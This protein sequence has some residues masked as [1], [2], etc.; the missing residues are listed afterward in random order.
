MSQKHTETSSQ[1]IKLA[2]KTKEYKFQIRA[3]VVATVLTVVCLLAGVLTHYDRYYV[4]V[5]WEIGFGAAFV[6]HCVIQLILYACFKRRIK[7]KKAADIRAI[8]LDG[9][10]AATDNERKFATAIK[11]KYVAC[12]LYI[13]L[14]F[15][16][17]LLCAFVG[18]FTSTGIWLSILLAWPG[19]IAVIPFLF[20]EDC[21][22]KGATDGTLPQSDFPEIYAVVNRAMKAVGIKKPVYVFASDEG[23]ACIYTHKNCFVVELGAPLLALLN[24]EELYSVLLHELGHL[25]DIYYGT[26]KPQWLNMAIDKN[27]SNPLC[28][29]FSMFFLGHIIASYTYNYVVYSISVSERIEYRA[30]QVMVK[31]CDAQVASDAMAKISYIPLYDYEQKLFGRNNYAD[32]EAPQHATTVLEQ[33]FLSA[34]ATEKDRW[35][36]MICKEISPQSSTHPLTRDRIA[37]MGGQMR[38]VDC[39]SFET[40]ASVSL[41]TLTGNLPRC[42]PRITPKTERSTTSNPKS[43]WTNGLPTA[44]PT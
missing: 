10:S 35:F 19:L 22:P 16:F 37:A 2:P 26:Q 32:E 28:R 42:T 40:N 15:I 18:G 27:E 6:L 33:E 12:R 24:D 34:V 13:W 20:I 44:N 14:F 39:P 8:Y 21:K 7:R 41:P 23:S 5:W 3:F 11:L 9:K 1:E 30:D 43:K 4:S 25:T 31:H 29:I 36:S 17:C 38:Q